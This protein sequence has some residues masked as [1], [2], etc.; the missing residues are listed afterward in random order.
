M[1]I[2]ASIMQFFEQHPDEVLYRNDIASSLDLTEDQV[3][4]NMR[5]VLRTPFSACITI[6]SR[7]NAW[8]YTPLSDIAEE[9]PPT[10]TFTLVSELN[11]GA[12]VLQDGVGNL[13]RATKIDVS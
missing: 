5:N 2:A 8:M 13:F 6:V 7:G 10:E 12:L 4:D 1:N 9:R 3:R 11:N